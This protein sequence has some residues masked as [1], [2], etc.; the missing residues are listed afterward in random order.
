[1]AIERETLV[2]LYTNMLTI[3][4][5]EE[6][7]AE[8]FAAGQ[9]PGFVHLYVGEEATATGVCAHLRPDDYITSTHRGHGHLISKGGD[10]NRMMAELFGK[11]TGYCKGKGGSMHIADLDLGIL[12][13]NGIVGGG[14]PIASGA[15]FAI[16]YRGSDQVVACFFGDGASNQGTFH[17]G[18]NLS[19]V[20]KLP[21]VFVA[22]NNMYGISCSQSQSMSVPDIADRA[23]AYDVPGV[24]VDG[25]DVLAVYEA[26][27]E[28]I[29]RAR[30]GAG[31][32]LIECKTYRHRGHFE[33]DPTVYRTAEELQIWLEKDP[34]PHFEARLLD[35]GVLSHQDLARI[36]EDITSKITQA[37]QFAEESPWPAPAELL[38]DVYTV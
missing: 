35:M 11:S 1:M 32:T 8:H 28:A 10:L 23:A 22:E 20:W 19:A 9:I 33:G 5:F 7:V 36:Q 2:W 25:N 38:D 3:R 30:E 15:G 16:R 17:E 31:P 24:V 34:I 18:L 26:A 37:V 13:A 12:G 27:G 6:T 21:V 14:P 4:R 29:K